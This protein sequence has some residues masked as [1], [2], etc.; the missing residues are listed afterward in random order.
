MLREARVLD[1]GG[2]M[3]AWWM[4]SLPGNAGAVLGLCAAGGALSLHELESSV[5]LQSPGVL[6]LAQ[7]VLGWLH[8]ARYEELSAGGTTIIGIALL[9]AMIGA[10]GWGSRGR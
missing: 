5:M 1:G 10:W 6:S 8:Y 9:M 4:S 7:T 3:L 2:G